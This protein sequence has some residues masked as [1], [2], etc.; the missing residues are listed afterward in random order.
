MVFVVQKVYNNKYR[1]QKHDSE[2]IHSFSLMI[3][4][5][6]NFSACYV[7]IFLSSRVMR[8][9]LHDF[10]LERGRSISLHIAGSPF[11]QTSKN[12]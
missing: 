5:G 10:H 1:Q 6:D 9:V 8:F 12:I 4:D 7:I 11:K 2:M 3:P